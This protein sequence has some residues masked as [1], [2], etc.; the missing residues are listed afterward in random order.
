M[1]GTRSDVPLGE[2]KKDAGISLAEFDP[3]VDG[4]RSPFVKLYLPVDIRRLHKLYVGR[5]YRFTMKLH[6]T[7]CEMH[8]HCLMRA[9]FPQSYDDDAPS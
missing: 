2:M 8:G 7:L 5:Q 3:T 6:N 1:R 4:R 9:R